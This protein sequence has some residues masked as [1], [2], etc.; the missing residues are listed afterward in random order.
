METKERIIELVRQN[1]ISMEEA[2]DLLEAA[3]QEHMDMNLSDEVQETQETEKIVENTHN[4]E[5]EEVQQATQEDTQKIEAY[6]EQIDRLSKQID[7]KSEAL[8][9]AQQRIREFEILAEID[10]LTEEMQEQVR[11][12]QERKRDLD[13][14]IQALYDELDEAKNQ[15]AALQ[16]KRVSSY[17]EDVKEFFERNTEKVSDTASA[18]GEEG[19]RLGHWV[20][21][22]VQDFMDN[23]KMR[24][25]QFN[26]NIP[27]I[28]ESEQNIE[29]EVDTSE[30]KNVLIRIPNGSIE[31][32]SHDA[33][34]LY[35]EGTAQL[36]GNFEQSMLDR[37]ETGGLVSVEAED[38]RIDFESPR[39]LF[40]GN[41]WLPKHAYQQFIIESWNGDVQ[42]EHLTSE[43]LTINSKNGNITIQQSKVAH[44]ES[45]QINGN[46]L[47]HE[48]E[49][50]FA[51]IHTYNGDIRVVNQVNNI[52]AQTLAGD[53]YITKRV[54]SD[55]NMNLKTVSGDIKVSIPSNMNLRAYTT[56]DASNVK[57]RLPNASEEASDDTQI[58]QRFTNPEGSQANIHTSQVTGV[59]YLKDAEDFE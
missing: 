59:L 11:Q 58:I 33:E 25:V 40:K 49:F 55:A 20:K 35:L 29:V 14:E 10:S 15:R 44:F 16:R 19:R 46:A 36:Y 50:D 39:I 1:V 17:T 41:L 21:G 48:V 30:A 4:P 38:V 47:L 53:I 27:W 13:T 28:K 2:L 37:W 9:I 54:V 51:D 8:V 42:L 12:L 7:T 18:V 3:G 57:L 23:F 31:V 24:D 56:N 52:D 34:H 43:N 26:M 5:I 45:Q 6:T 32:H 22:S